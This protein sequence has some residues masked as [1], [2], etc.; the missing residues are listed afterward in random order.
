[1]NL[2]SS[3]GLS[4]KGSLKKYEN[5]PKDTKAGFKKPLYSC[6]KP[7]PYQEKQKQYAVIGLYIT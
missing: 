2:E 3:T 4:S 7:P 1:M 6:Q 5:T